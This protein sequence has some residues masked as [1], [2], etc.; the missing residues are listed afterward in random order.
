MT[1]WAIFVSGQGTNLQHVLELERDR[2]QVNRIQLVIADREC[3]A[4]ERAKKFNKP[5]IIVDPKS[6]N[7]ETRLIEILSEYQINSIFLLG[8]MRILKPAFLDRWKGALINLHPSLLPKFKGANAIRDA[9]EADESHLGVTLHK[10]VADVDSGKILRQLK[11]ERD[12]SLPLEQTI[13]I[14][15]Q[16]ER[17]IVGDFLMDLEAD[18]VRR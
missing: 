6:P 13:E 1:S 5:A 9:I 17:K 7:F 15:H 12:R 18:S 8:Y 3:F 14:V 11:F 16:Y 10:V 2:L 4:L